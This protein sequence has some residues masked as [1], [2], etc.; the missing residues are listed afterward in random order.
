[1]GNDAIGGAIGTLEE[2]V[3]KYCQAC[4]DRV[5]PFVEREFSLREAIARQ[6]ASLFADLLCY[7]L[8][9]LWAVPYLTTRK[10]IESLDKVGWS[11]L[12]PLFDQVPS[13]IKTRYQREVERKIYQEV[14]EWPYD[15]ETAQPGTHALV[16]A[17]RAHPSLTPLARAVAARRPATGAH[18]EVCRLVDRYSS[19]R[20]MVSDLAGSAGTI[21]VGWML[22]KDGTLGLFGIG[23]RLA[24]ERARETAVSHFTFGKRL[25]TTWYRMFPPEPSP[26]DVA[27]ATV[28]IGALITIL[29]L[30]AGV[31]SDPLGK[32]VGF[33]KR[34]LHSLV[35]DL[36]HRLRAQLIKMLKDTWPGHPV[37][38]PAIEQRDR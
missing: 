20:M 33:Q 9:A 4:R 34:K 31:A 36:E 30:V 27:M 28:L 18:Q 38:G 35:D 23:E 11:V 17:L 5:A 7:P 1:M 8:N 12:T 29:C 25:G 32:A 13:G 10:V 6:R 21:A 14:L 15:P 19:G 16:D 2:V 3:E 22:F 37:P 26:T 24:R